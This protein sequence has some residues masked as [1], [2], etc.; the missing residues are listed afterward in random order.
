MH[1][2]HLSPDDIDQL[3]DGEETL[4]DAPLW[5]HVQQCDACVTALARAQELLGALQALPEFAPSPHFADGVMGQ[6]QVFEPWY[7]ALA[8]TVRPFIPAGRLAQLAA[9][10]V[11]LTV[12]GLGTAAMS[13][14][15]ARADMAVFLAAIGMS[16]LRAQLQAAGADIA[17]ALVGPSALAALSSSPAGTRALLLGGFLVTSG[18]CVLGMRRLAAAPHDER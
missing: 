2:H 18:L 15:L 4:E 6:V 16:E 1:D 12:A 5:A 13:W 11:A 10:V 3:L 9:S 8:Q 17:D 7:V 14:A